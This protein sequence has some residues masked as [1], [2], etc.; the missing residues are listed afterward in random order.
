MPATLLS[1]VRALVG[2]LPRLLTRHRGVLVLVLVATFAEGA[3]AAINMLAL[4]VFVNEVLNLYAYFGLIGGT[5][6]AVE[7]VMKSV[8][9]TLADR[10]GRW[11]FLSA[12]PVVSGCTALLVVALGTTVQRLLRTNDYAPIQYHGWLPIALVLV[13]LLVIRAIDGVAAAAF[14]PTMFATMADAAPE[15][16]RTSAMSTLTVAYMVGVAL[17]PPLAGWANDVSPL[18]SHGSRV[19]VRVLALPEAPPE[20]EKTYTLRGQLLA[21][22]PDR[23]TLTV[24]TERRILF[25]KQ[26]VLRTVT[27]GE[28]TTILA[29]DSPDNVEAGTLDDLRPGMWVGIQTAGNK[30]AA[31][32]VVGILF[33]VTAVLAFLFIPRRPPVRIATRLLA[34]DQPP[35]GIDADLTLRGRVRSVDRANRTLVITPDSTP[36][37]RQPLELAVEVGEKSAVQVGGEAGGPEAGG[38]EQI[39]PGMWIGVQPATD[40]EH[41]QPLRLSDLTIAWRLAPA[42]VLTALVVFISVGSLASVAAVYAKEVFHLSDFQFGRLFILP[43]VVIGSLTLPIGLLSDRW[44]R[45]RSVHVG[46][47]LATVALVAMAAVATIRSLHFLRSELVLGMLATVLGIGFVMGLPAWLAT[48]ADIA[49]EGRRAQVIGAVATAEGIGAFIGY[50]ISPMLFAQRHRIPWTIHAPMLIAAIALTLGFLVSLF[51]LRQP[52]R[53]GVN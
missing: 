41:D 27:I 19:V 10:Y 48:V 17:G 26:T 53:D 13:P 38:L 37:D 21:V 8:M 9:G 30:A 35:P 2:R 40:E 3:Y 44:G 33:F 50:V 20:V 42:L 14:W 25:R 43:A 49:G 46:I 29:G 1:R 28:P 31:F 7:A 36:A 11:K 24:S 16:R 32:I 22:D 12:A 23:E 4:Q 51:T 45:I 52:P 34:L 6:L 39:R 5:F 15:H 18:A 47:G